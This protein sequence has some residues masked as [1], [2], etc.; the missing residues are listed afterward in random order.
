MKDKLYQKY[1]FKITYLTYKKDHIFFENNNIKYMICKTELSNN[2]L[3]ELDNIVRYLEKYAIFFHQIVLNDGGYLFEFGSQN[4]VVL[5]MRMLERKIDFSEILKVS[6]IQVPNENFNLIE[7]KIDFLEQYLANYENLDFE[8]FNYFIGLA[9]NSISLFNLSNS[10]KNYINHKRIHYNETTIDFYNPLN[11]IIDYK[12]RDI[13]EYSKN[14]FVFGDDRIIEILKYI[15][16]D[17]WY[18]YFARVVFPSF[19]FDEIDN[20][21]INNIKMDKK[22]I[23]SLANSFES[24]IRELYIYI[25][26]YVKM[27]YIEWLGQVNNF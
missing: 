5:K 12:T 4:Y 15:S 27:P 16:I 6:F 19:Y 17:S 3:A 21:I 8:N 20:Y 14:L 11:I 22:R 25:N 1:G 9:E 7:S 13:A 2:E 23:R 18:T 26:S 10:P 24:K